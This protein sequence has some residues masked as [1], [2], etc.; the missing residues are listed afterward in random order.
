[1]F[2]IMIFTSA[3]LQAVI[4]YS[5]VTKE[6]WSRKVDEK[7]EWILPIRFF[8]TQPETKTFSYRSFDNPSSGSV[9]YFDERFVRFPIRDTDGNRV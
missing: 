4:I 5:D 2:P 9:H 8:H 6:W 1:M 3:R 7:V